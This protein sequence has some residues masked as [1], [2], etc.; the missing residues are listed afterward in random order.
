MGI[1][2]IVALASLA[3]TAAGTGYNVSQGSKKPPTP[4]PTP[5]PPTLDTAAQS[6]AKLADTEQEHARRKKA[7][8]GAT[9]TTNAAGIA[10]V[11]SWTLGSVAG[12]NTLTATSVGLTGSPLRR[13]PRD[14]T[15]V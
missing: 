8:T 14:A 11:G 12:V 2:E 5:P 10:T 15:R 6:A 9:Q 1:E 7:I 13:R 3:M 4:P